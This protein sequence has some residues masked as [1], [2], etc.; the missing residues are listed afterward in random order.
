MT[1]VF[2][3]VAEQAAVDAAMGE[4]AAAIGATAVAVAAPVAV[5]AAG[6]YVDKVL[7]TNPTWNHFWNS[8][9]ANVNNWYHSATDF[10]FGSGG[11]SLATVHGMVQLA[12]H[13]ANALSRELFMQASVAAHAGVHVLAHAVDAVRTD[14]HKLQL[15]IHNVDTSIATHFLQGIATAEHYTDAGLRRLLDDAKSLDRTVVHNVE[16]WVQTDIANPLLREVAKVEG[17]VDTLSGALGGLIS[18]EVD[19]LLR[20]RLAPILA[21]V[22]GLATAVSAITAEMEECVEPMCDTFGP[23][24]DLGQLLKKLSVLKWA[25]IL[26]A[27]EATDVKDLE[28]LAETVAGT[29]GHIGEWVASHVLDELSSEHR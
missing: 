3:P 9:G 20:S 22:A 16:T 21:T 12:L 25:A 7:L 19:K 26:A 27:L 28:H 18:S 15:A 4:A 23:K 29:E 24:S 17:K 11:V 2:V 1:A 14:I 10:F 5:V 13:G 8:V 6:A